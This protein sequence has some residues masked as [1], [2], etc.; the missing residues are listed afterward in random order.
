MKTKEKEI[1]SKIKELCELMGDDDNYIIFHENDENV[2]IAMPKDKNGADTN[3]AVALARVIDEYLRQKTT[4]EG[5]MRLSKI[6]VGAIATLISASG[7]SSEISPTIGST[8]SIASLTLPIL[9][10]V[11]LADVSIKKKR[12]IFL[13]GILSFSIS[14][15]IVFF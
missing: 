10:P 11:I 14:P 15:I 6:I 7:F 8:F 5:V 3:I 1:E 13:L 2:R 12:I 9:D 4:N